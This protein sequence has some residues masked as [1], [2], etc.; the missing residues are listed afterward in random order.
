MSITEGSLPSVCV[1][2]TRIGYRS[3]FEVSRGRFAGHVA[4]RI[5]VVVEGQLAPRHRV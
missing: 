1:R 3:P 5:V 4:I 2:Y